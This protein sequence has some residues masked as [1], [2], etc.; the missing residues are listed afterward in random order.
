MRH[1]NNRFLAF[2][3][4]FLALGT[5]VSAQNAPNT[6]PPPPSGPPAPPPRSTPPA[7]SQVGSGQQGQPE[8]ENNGVYVFKARVE[9]VVLHATVYDSKGRMVTNLDRAAFQVFED[10]VPQNITSFHR[11][12]VPVAVGIVI[13]NSGSMR[14]KRPAVNQAAVNFVRASNPQDEAFIVNFN[15]EYYLDQDFTNKVPQL[16]EALQ[17]IDSRGGTALYDAIVASADHLKKNARLDKKVILVVTDGEDNASRESLEQAVRRLQAENG[18][19]VYTIGLLG[20]EKQRRARRA[21]ATI[22]ED[23]GGVSFFPKDLSE[24]DA[25]TQEVAHDIRNQYTIGYKPIR[26]QSQGGYR[27]VRV[28]AKAKGFNKLQVRTRTGYYAGTARAAN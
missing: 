1:R 5:W 24:V 6:A 15:D 19:T 20:T 25:I 3:A 27:S 7:G 16:Q 28:E 17:K 14:D 12:D 26:P 21:L 18:P 10:G 13:D 23:T 22:A 11:E 2:I 8:G 9:E 4:L